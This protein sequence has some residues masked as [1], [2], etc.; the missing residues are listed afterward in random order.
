MSTH[1]CLVSAQAAPNL[2]PVLNPEIKPNEVVLLVSAKMQSAADAL[3]AVLLELGIRVSTIALENEHSYA[4][5]EQTLLSVAEDRVG[6][7]ILLNL[8]G[9]TKLMAL[10]AQSVAQAYQWRSFYVDMDTDAIVWLDQQTPGEK[11]G[12]QLR[13]THYL[14]SYGFDLVEKPQRPQI[15]PQQRELTQTLITQIGSLEGALTQ[16]NW[17]AQQAEDNRQ[18]QVR[19]DERQQDSRNLEA[20]LRHFET[21][22]ALSVNNGTIQFPSEAARD[23]VKGG[24]LEH[25]VFNRVCAL[26]GALGIRDKAMNLEVTNQGVKNEL[27][28]A[29]M[30][31]NRLFVIECKTARMDK[32]EAPK[33]NDTLFKLAENCRRIGGL[34]TR[35][36][37]ASYRPLRDSEKKLAKALNIQIV[38]S[39]ELRDLDARLRSWIGR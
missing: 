32:P 10:V 16:L 5:I 7:E 35:G 15:T 13:L 37:L 12:E 2:L 14:K 20:L 18:L 28:I 6:Q 17:L 3:Q 23:F 8:T 1:I 22:A 19:M 33:A 21:A 34:G 26:T 39:Q 36:M 11:L 4:D 30:A 9:G 25:H 27:D 24:W 29:L 38:C 31:R